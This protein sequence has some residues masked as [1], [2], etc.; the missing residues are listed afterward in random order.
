MHCYSGRIGRFVVAIFSRLPSA[1]GSFFLLLPVIISQS[2][3]HLIITSGVLH[4]H[5]LI[6]TRA[7]FRTG[8]LQDWCGV[9]L[10]D[11]A[12][13]KKSK[14]FRPGIDNLPRDMV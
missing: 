5:H 9:L 10:P 1:G 11:K 13:E 8:A 6:I 7:Y 14:N 12:A 4:I 2:S 3:H